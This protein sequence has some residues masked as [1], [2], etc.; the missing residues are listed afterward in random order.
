M[1]TVFPET[2]IE[3]WE[4]ANQPEGKTGEWSG[5]RHPEGR[6]FRVQPV[7]STYICYIFTIFCV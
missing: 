1:F 7:H 4:S 3:P 5:L 2:S 6:F